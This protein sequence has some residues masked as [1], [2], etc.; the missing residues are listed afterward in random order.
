MSRSFIDLRQNQHADSSSFWPS[1][2]DIMMVIVMIFMLTSTVLIVR[3]WELVQ[4]LT[5]TMEAKVLAAD[6]ARR[7]TL[8]STSLGE[9]LDNAQY[10]L[11]MLRLQLM[12]LSESNDLQSQMLDDQQLYLNRQSEEKGDLEQQLKQQLIEVVQLKQ[13]LQQQQ[14]EQDRLNASLK[15]EQD[16][17]ATLNLEHTSLGSDFQQ[18]QSQLEQL[19]GQQQREQK[20][21][22]V[23]QGQY[24]QLKSK[25]DKLVRPARSSKGR[26]IVSVRYERDET[27]ETIHLKEVSGGDESYQ[28]VSNEIL[29]Q[30]L[31]ELKK[32]EDGGL[33]IKIIIPPESGLTY[34]EAWDFMRSLLDQYDYYYQ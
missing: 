14:E 11:S 26:Y 34:N 2:T 13:L 19:Q 33:Y 21:L 15:N 3:N 29:H 23:M 8:T 24:D 5:A 6:E 20:R 12:Q 1:F 9:Q 27:A 18:Q 32:R 4:E 22:G 7:A 16:R 31:Q 30:R 28:I 25:Y 10:Q 17:Y